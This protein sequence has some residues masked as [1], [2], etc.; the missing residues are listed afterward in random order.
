MFLPANIAHHRSTPRNTHFFALLLVRARIVLFW[1]LLSLVFFG[2]LCG[3]TV[4]IVYAFLG[5][6]SIFQV[7]FR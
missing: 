2:L 1:I 4:W 3:L 7:I 5:A 6:C